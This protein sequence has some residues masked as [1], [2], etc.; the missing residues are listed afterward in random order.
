M[1]KLGLKRFAPNR[2]PNKPQSYDLVSGSQVPGSRFRV[3]KTILVCLSE[4][5]RC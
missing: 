5:S 1:R 3:L 2:I 4:R